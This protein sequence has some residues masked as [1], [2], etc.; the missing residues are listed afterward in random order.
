MDLKKMIG[1]KQKVFRDTGKI[2]HWAV[3]KN[4]IKELLDWSKRLKLKE[5]YQART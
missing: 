1:I 3:F 4:H 5:I 2:N